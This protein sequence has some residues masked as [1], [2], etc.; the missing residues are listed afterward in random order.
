M[1]NPQNY[2]DGVGNTCKL[3]STF[4]TKQKFNTSSL[5]YW[6]KA[7]NEDEIGFIEFLCKHEMEAL[8]YK[9]KCDNYGESD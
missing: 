6:E 1:I 2:V 8:N 4:E 3:N 5:Q 9:T 7:L